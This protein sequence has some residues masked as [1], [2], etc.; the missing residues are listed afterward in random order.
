MNGCHL[1]DPNDVITSTLRECDAYFPPNL[2][3]FVFFL[4][5]I[6][7]ANNHIFFLSDGER[8]LCETKH[9]EVIVN[10]T[11]DDETYYTPVSWMQLKKK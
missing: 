2:L 4:C 1:T 9:L 8:P 11:D 5:V 7:I 6:F 3:F 10:T